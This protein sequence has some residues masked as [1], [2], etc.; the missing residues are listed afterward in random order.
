MFILSN[1]TVFLVQF[2]IHLHLR[3][4]QNAEIAL[5]EATR[6]ISAF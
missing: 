5:A 4:F 3:V 6:E 2:E 1:H